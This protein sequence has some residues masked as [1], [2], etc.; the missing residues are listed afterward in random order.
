MSLLNRELQLEKW[1]YEYA[2]DVHYDR[3]P[4]LPPAQT[5]VRP[6]GLTGRYKALEGYHSLGPVADTLRAIYFMPQ[7]DRDFW[8][9]RLSIFN[10]D[11]EDKIHNRKVTVS[12]DP[13][14]PRLKYGFFDAPKPKD[15]DEVP[16]E[17]LAIVIPGIGGTY[18]NQAALATAEE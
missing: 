16:P 1:Y 2:K 10:S 13:D 9:A 11:F 3:L 7:K 12:D 18:N 6:E 14:R 17:K 15:K 8:Y 4:E 5:P